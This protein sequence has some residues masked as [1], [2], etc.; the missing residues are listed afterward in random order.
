MLHIDRFSVSLDTELLAAFDRHIASKGYQ[1]RS[2]AIRDMIRDSL[3]T[4]RRLEGDEPITAILTTVCDHRVGESAA[5]LR[6]CLAAYADIVLGSV[7]VNVDD[8]RDALAITLKGPA[9]MVQTV[10]NKVQAMR[11]SMHGHL[12]VIPAEE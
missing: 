12:S 1:N 7:Y 11:G 10:A 6:A 9:E 4:S 8:H 3:V 5:R 2:E